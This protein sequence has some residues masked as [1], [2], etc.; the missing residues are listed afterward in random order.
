MSDWQNAKE[1]IKLDFD[2]DGFIVLSDFCS[3]EQM[4][5]ISAQL[6]RYVREV[7]PRLPTEEHF[8]EDK[9]R[10]ETLKYTRSLE[11]HDEHFKKLFASEQFVALA[12]LLLDGPIVGRD[13]SMFDKPPRIGELTP[14]HQDGYYF[15]L[16][17]SEALTMWLAVDAVDEQNG[18]IRYVRGS[19]RRGLRAHHRTTTLGFSQGVS[20]YGPDDEANAVPII[21]Q[22]GDLLI[23]HCDTIHRADANCSDRPRRAFG[24]V[25]YAARARPDT[26][27]VEGYQK[28]LMADLVET[29]KI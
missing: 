16:E 29:G 12:E 6:E 27:R 25:Y 28:S 20:D 8:Y 21:A 18:C 5:E 19:H 10:P 24:F 23:H 1:K 3:P 11:L 14:P 17:P 7:I 22:S 4:R 26:R 13:L 2:R 9:T 15:M